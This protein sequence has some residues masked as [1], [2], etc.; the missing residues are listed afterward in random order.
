M[1]GKGTVFHAI[2]NK[3]HIELRAYRSALQMSFAVAKVKSLYAGMR[4][5]GFDTWIQN[6]IDTVWYFSQY[7]RCNTEVAFHSNV[8]DYHSAGYVSISE[9]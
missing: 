5:K 9:N 2:Y 1:K 8:I 7:P 4:S 3:F 6:Y